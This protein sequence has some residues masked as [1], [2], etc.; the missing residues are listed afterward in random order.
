MS[1]SLQ[2]GALAP[3]T[4]GSARSL[5]ELIEYLKVKP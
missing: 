4:F 1:L 3:S 2:M 5:L